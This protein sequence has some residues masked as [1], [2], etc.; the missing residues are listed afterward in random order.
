MQLGQEKKKRTGK[1]QAEGKALEAGGGHHI[2]SR[3]EIFY[4]TLILVALTEPQAKAT[5]F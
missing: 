5:S 4:M 2:L 3:L 1:G